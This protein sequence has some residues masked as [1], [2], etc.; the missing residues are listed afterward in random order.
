LQ[1][2]FSIIFDGTTDCSKKEACSIVLRFV[3][4]CD[5]RGPKISE[6]LFDVFTTG[7]TS[8]AN[9]ATLITEC[10]DSHRFD[11]NWHISQSY[12][13]AS[14]MRGAVSG[15]QAR[16]SNRAPK[17]MYT[18]CYAH[19]MNL[20]IEGMIASCTPIRNAIG[21]LEE[22]YVY[23]AGHKRHD[24]FFE[25]QREY[26]HKKTFKR[27]G[28]STRTWRSVEDA[29]QVVLSRYS[30]LCQ[31]LE[32]LSQ[33]ND[34]ST[35]T[36]AQGLLKQLR[37]ITIL[38]CLHIIDDILS[39]TGPVS[40]IFQATS[41]DLAVAV[42]TVNSCKS[43][44]LE[45]RSDRQNFDTTVEKAKLFA[46]SHGID[47]GIQ[48]SSK[49][50]IRRRYA[51]G[52]IDAAAGHNSEG[53]QT[54]EDKLYVNVYAPAMDFVLSDLSCRF[55]DSIR[56]VIC[57]MMTFSAGSLLSRTAV[58]TNDIDS[59]CSK[60]EVDVDVVVR[61]LNSFIPVFQTN[62]TLVN[63]DDIDPPND[64]N[65]S[66]NKLWIRQT[67]LQPYRL[68][69]LLSSFPTLL[70]VYKILVTVAVTSASAERA[71]SKVK[72]V[73][74]RLRSTMSDDYFSSLLLIAS[75][76]DLIDSLDSN[77]VINRFAALSPVLRKHLVHC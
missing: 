56:P 43:V 73:K 77:D 3:E 31:S 29:T 75:E 25:S 74:T 68:L 9:L 19:R 24:A 1:K 51:D 8:A 76:K 52:S 69:H 42:N 61:E 12:D 63:M 66:G 10:L 50:K 62:H 34:A 2:A 35:V 20:V 36:G 32:V 17:A 70:M 72:L 27:T 11:L 41:T 26:S 6:R 13:G 71:M 48:Q 4:L 58:T 5:E 30:E 54:E 28:N 57:Q 14:N 23:F 45:R 18:W 39:V 59:F 44:L 21:I 46:E 67:F 55:D 15:L 22:L 38:I 33:S 16:I 60:Y 65:H 64:G 40:R 53:Q 47:P 49:R 37:D 7:D